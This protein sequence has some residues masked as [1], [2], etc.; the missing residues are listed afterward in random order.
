MTF[1]DMNWLLTMS[2]LLSLPLVLLLSKPTNAT[3]SEPVQK[4]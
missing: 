3:A 2:L 4:P 1:N